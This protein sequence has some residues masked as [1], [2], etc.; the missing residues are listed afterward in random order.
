MKTFLSVAICFCMSFAAVAS[1]WVSISTNAPYNGI[2]RSGTMNISV[3]VGGYE[4]ATVDMYLAL[5]GPNGML[6]CYTAGGLGANGAIAPIVTGWPVSALSLSPALQFTVP[7]D[8]ALG[9]YT[10]YYILCRTGKSVL[11]AGNWHGFGYTAW[12]VASGTPHPMFTFV[13]EAALPGMH[14]QVLFHADNTSVTVNSTMGVEQ[15]T[16][17]TYLYTFYTYNAQTGALLRTLTSPIG[18]ERLYLSADGTSIYTNHYSGSSLTEKNWRRY[19]AATGAFVTDFR[20]DTFNGIVFKD[21][22]RPVYAGQPGNPYSPDGTKYYAASGST[23][24]VYSISA[25]GAIGSSIETATGSFTRPVSTT[26][27]ADGKKLYVLNDTITSGMSVVVMTTAPLVEVASIPLGYSGAAFPVGVACADDGTA[28]V[29]YTTSLYI[30]GENSSTGQIV[31]IDAESNQSGTVGSISVAS[32]PKAL[33][34][35]YG[36][37]VSRDGKQLAAVGYRGGYAI[38]FFNTNR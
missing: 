22:V 29:S 6:R 11:D 37:A 3:T 30:N 34:Q 27:S 18:V 36:L 19:D 4:P 33:D 35:F 32:T 14:S 5:A 38:Q 31:A 26:A 28:Y 23:L 8:F 20:D 17:S 9:D 21:G 16:P 12:K 1:E 2:A 25:S 13:K 24:T 7:S 15:S 10:W